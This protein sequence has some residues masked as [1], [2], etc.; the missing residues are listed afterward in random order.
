M[1]IKKTEGKKAAEVAA[2][3][4]ASPMGMAQWNGL[5]VKLLLK[6]EAENIVRAGKNGNYIIFKDA[7]DKCHYA[8]K[9]N[10]SIIISHE[11]TEAEIPGYKFVFLTPY[12]TEENPAEEND[13]VATRSAQNL[14]EILDSYSRIFAA[15]KS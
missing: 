12:H 14:I 6:A 3:Q 4:A 10:A 1:E 11:I 13:G 15:S 2:V 8:M 5:T 7:A 9:R